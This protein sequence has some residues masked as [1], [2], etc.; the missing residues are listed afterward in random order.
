MISQRMVYGL[1]GLNLLLLVVTLTNQSRPLA[2]DP[3]VSPMIR[4]RGLEIVDSLGK[5]RASISILPPSTVDGRTYP[6]SVLLRLIDPAGKP[7]VK[8]GAS[9]SGTGMTLTNTRDGGIQMLAHDTVSL[10]RI[11]G[12]D[13]RVQVIRP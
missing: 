4:G 8:I 11:E 10:V 3:G 1:T 7:V 9:V 5:V 2:A 13:G 6:Q 12:V